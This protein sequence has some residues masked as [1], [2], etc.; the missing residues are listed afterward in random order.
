MKDYRNLIVWQKAHQLTLSIYEM[1]KQFPAEEKYGLVSQI[2]RASS[3]IPTNIAEG[4][5]HESKGQFIRYL[6]IASGSA[7]ETEY[8]LLLSK[9]LNFILQQDYETALQLITE[10][11]KMMRSLI[12]KSKPS[13]N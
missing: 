8:L 5:G 4:C 11:K 13:D 2:R 9:D 3:S 10:I 7:N 12:A 1:S 6:Q